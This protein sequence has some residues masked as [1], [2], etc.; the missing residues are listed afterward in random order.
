MHDKYFTHDI[1]SQIDSQTLP[2]GAEILPVSLQ[3]VENF[4]KLIVLFC[5]SYFFIFSVPELLYHCSAKY[6]HTKIK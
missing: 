5:N 6:H 3:Q 2:C 1:M 4:N